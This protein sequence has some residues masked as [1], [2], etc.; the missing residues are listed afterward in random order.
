MNKQL[1]NS[2]SLIEQVNF[3][4]EK[5]QNGM[6]ITQICNS[7]NISYNTVRDRFSKNFY[8]YNKL[9]NRYECVE[10]IFPLDEEAIERALEKV[11]TK[12]FNTTPQINNSSNEKL[13]IEPM[14]EEIVNR[15][16]RIY[17]KVLKD[18][19]IFCEN[20]NYNQYDILSQFI[21]DGII[22]YSC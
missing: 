9:T 17:D 14:D 6:N 19:I 11:V 21:I 5:L 7:I 15:S 12:I 10:K 4:N 18:F 3:F 22:K 1:F 20:S 16:F 13:I 8:T 2:L